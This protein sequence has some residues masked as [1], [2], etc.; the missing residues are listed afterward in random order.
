[1]S[2]AT[3]TRFNSPTFSTRS[4]P[5]PRGS[6]SMSSIPTCS[7]IGASDVHKREKTGR[8][9]RSFPPQTPAS[10]DS[11]GSELLVR[12]GRRAID[13]VLGGLLGIA[14]RLLAFALCL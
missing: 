9:G 5:L 14:Q 12:C 8:D 13:R 4:F 7:A 1:M 10:R 3:N 11:L 6:R 2:R